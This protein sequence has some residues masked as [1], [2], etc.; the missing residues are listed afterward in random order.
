VVFQCCGSCVRYQGSYDDFLDAVEVITLTV[1]SHN[2][3][4]CC[5]ASDGWQELPADYPV[6]SI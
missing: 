6:G 4:K 5:N 1:I 3:V 2:G